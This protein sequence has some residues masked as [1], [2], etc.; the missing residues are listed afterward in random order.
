MVK[1][2]ANKSR[3]VKFDY[4]GHGLDNLGECRGMNMN[5]NEL[6]SKSVFLE[7]DSPTGFLNR[8]S[9]RL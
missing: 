1:L 5:Y 3:K 8:L 7:R 2:T 6:Y 9:H 4:I